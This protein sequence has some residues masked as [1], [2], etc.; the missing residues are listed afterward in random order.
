MGIR[1]RKCIPCSCRETWLTS[2]LSL[3]PVYNC[4]HPRK[5]LSSV[6]FGRIVRGSGQLNGSKDRCEVNHVSMR[7]HGMNFLQRIP[8]QMTGNSL[9]SKSGVYRGINVNV[10][11]SGELFSSPFDV[12]KG[13]RG[14]MLSWMSAVVHKLAI[15]GID[16]VYRAK[17]HNLILK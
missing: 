11:A 2:H 12:S 8:I 1:G 16:W 3:L 17:G 9:G 4:T 10:L 13:N 7:K 5:P 15:R 14:K 6:A